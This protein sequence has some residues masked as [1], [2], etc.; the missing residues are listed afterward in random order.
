M[1]FSNLFKTGGHD[2]MQK[3]ATLW[4]NFIVNSIEEMENHAV[5]LRKESTLFLTK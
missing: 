5:T 4:S 1:E 2:D 3:V